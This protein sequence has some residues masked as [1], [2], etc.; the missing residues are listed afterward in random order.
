M[1]VELLVIAYAL[2][3][4]LGLVHAGKGWWGEDNGFDGSIA[5]IGLCVF[6]MM[7]ILFNTKP[8]AGT[9]AGLLAGSSLI[10]S[11]LVFAISHQKDQQVN[12]AQRRERKAMIDNIFKD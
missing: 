4:A 8:D 7:V 10:H 12:E 2:L 9:G 6:V 1:I 5:S 11:A 3:F